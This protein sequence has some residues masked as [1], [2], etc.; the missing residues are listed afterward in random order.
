M[1]RSRVVWFVLLAMGLGWANPAGAEVTIGKEA[2]A[3][4]AKGSDGKEYRLADLR[5]KFVVLEWF[6]KGCPFVQKHYESGNMQK[7]Q[8]TYGQK[9]VV[10][11]S[12]V[13]SAKG[14]EGFMTPHDAARVRADWKIKS[15]ATLLDPR[16]QVGRL[17]EAKT[18][19]H[20]FLIDPKGVLVYKGAIDSKNTT[21]ADDIPASKNYVSAALDEALAGKPIAATDTKPYG[22]SVKYK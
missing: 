18:T 14:K 7:L 4:A 20:M 15:A 12:I 19:P 5:G 9:G 17:Y 6:N 8:E 16:G 1:K 10:W 11:L 2:P 21:D 22:C 3:F 13:S